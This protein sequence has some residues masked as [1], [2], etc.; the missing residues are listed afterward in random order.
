MRKIR[1]L[2]GG[3]GGTPTDPSESESLQV[4]PVTGNFLENTRLDNANGHLGLSPEVLKVQTCHGDLPP[5]ATQ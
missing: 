2:E 1:H 4:E 3:G 5:R